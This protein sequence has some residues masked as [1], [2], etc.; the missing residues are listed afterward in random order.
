M[1]G[2]LVMSLVENFVLNQEL[3]F[4]QPNLIS[5]FM[6]SLNEINSAIEFA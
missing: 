6:S 5:K 1:Y 4:K 3:V 2:L